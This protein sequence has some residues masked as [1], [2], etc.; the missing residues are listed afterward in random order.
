MPL[1]EVRRLRREGGGPF[2]TQALSP[3]AQEFEIAGPAGPLPLRV[4]SPDAPRGVYLHVHGGG[5]TWGER[6]EQDEDLEAIAALG[7]ACIAASYRLAPEHPYP[8]APDDCEAAALWLAREGERVFGTRRF[9]IGGDS[10]GAHLALVTLLRMRDRSNIMPFAGANLVAGCYD[11][12]LTPSV[13][14]WGPEKLV[15]N[16]RD[17][18]MF[19]RNFCGERDRADPD[20]SPLYADLS[21]MPPMLLTVGTKDLLL[22]DSLFLAARLAAAGAPCELSVA[23]G[24][25]HMFQRFPI[26]IAEKAH[27]RIRAF[28][29]GVGA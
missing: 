21:G 12:G 10:A 6:H 1:D 29:A 18:A 28:F 7:W 8:A 13:R 2:R 9:I 25:C 14:N 15:I 3:R 5:W 23:P 20:I 4:I 11:L 26:P 17:M 22:D 19:T 16:S 27:A 24:G